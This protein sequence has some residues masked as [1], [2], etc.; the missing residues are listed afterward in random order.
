M[1]KLDKQ[2]SV[3]AHTVYKTSDGKRVPSVTT[4]TKLVADQS[5]LIAWANRMGLEGTDSTKYRDEA[6]RIGTLGHYMIE[7]DLRDEDADLSE[8]SPAQIDQASNAFIKYLTW[9][10]EHTVEPVLVEE[11][12]VSDKYRF[13][14]TCDCLAYVNGQ[15]TLLDIKTGSGPYKDMLVQVA[16]YRYLLSE[17][18]HD[19]EQT[20]ILRI[21]R[22]EDEDTAW[23]TYSNEMMDVAFEAFLHAREVY[24]LLKKLKP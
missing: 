1:A 23:R 8:Y 4:I 12:M 16:A 3:K 2:K 14:G 17:L 13:G 22:S 19:V 20:G 10:Q 24:E 18:G 21:G 15:L 7:S 9:K 11:V 6:G 5:N